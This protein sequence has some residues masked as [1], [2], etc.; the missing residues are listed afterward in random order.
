MSIACGSLAPPA[1][2]CGSAAPP[3]PLLMKR[4]EPPMQSWCHVKRLRH[5]THKQGFQPQITPWCCTS[6]FS[7]EDPLKTCLQYQH[8]KQTCSKYSKQFLLGYSCKDRQRARAKV[9]PVRVLDGKR[10]NQRRGWWKMAPQ[11][12]TEAE[13]TPQQAQRSEVSS[14]MWSNAILLTNITG[15]QNKNLVLGTLL[16]RYG[17]RTIH[18]IW[19]YWAAN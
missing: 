8:L 17:F 3:L 13:Q 1:L 4:Q 18:C 9:E 11:T 16:T 12:N 14:L 10:R 2:A 19:Q 6:S 5:E 7:L 15:G